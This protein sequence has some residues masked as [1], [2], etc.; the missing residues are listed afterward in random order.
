MEGR[1]HGGIVVARANCTDPS[2][3][4]EM[5]DWYSNHHVP[6]ITRS[7]AVSNATRYVNPEAKG[8]DDDRK[9]LALYESN[10]ADLASSWAR[11]LAQAVWRPWN[12]GIIIHPALSK[13][14]VGVYKRFGTQPEPPSGKSAASVLMVLSDCEDPGREEEFN[15]WYDGVHVPD[16][17]ETGAYWSARR[18]V[19]YAL[20]PDQ[21]KY[22]A[23][24]E[25]EGD[26][27]SSLEALR[28]G[29]E[30]ANA[31]RSDA[32]AVRHLAAFNLVFSEA[33]TGVEAR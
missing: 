28:K 10:E 9:Y 19:N 7:G 16:I 23:L 21:P 33:K 29:L 22:L 14:W 2:R 27:P 18:F 31:E 1:S 11:N 5:N 30:A 32:I 20:G 15:R 4:A 13:V 6:D 17:L 25:S 3:E 24:Y 8:T 26:G 12:D